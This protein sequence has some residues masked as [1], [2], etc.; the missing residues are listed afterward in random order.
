MGQAADNA[1]TVDESASQA[2]NNATSSGG[3]TTNSTSQNPL[4][5]LMNL[6]K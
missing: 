5:M 3:N 6:F 2:A 4:D 1:T